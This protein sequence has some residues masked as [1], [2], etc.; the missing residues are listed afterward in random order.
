MM[1]N[2]WAANTPE[3][4]WGCLA[5]IPAEV[6]Q[7]AS[8]HAS[9]ELGLDVPVK[10]VADALYLTLGEG[11][12]GPD[13]WTLS[14]SRRLYY[15]L[16][17]LIPRP[18]RVAMRRLVQARSTPEPVGVP[19]QG[20]LGWPVEERYVRFLWAVMRAV[21]LELGV[22]E[23]PFRDFWPEGKRF[24]LVLTHDIETAEGQAFVP[25]VAALEA[26]LGFRSSFNF[27][28]ERY[29]LDEALI[30]ALRRDGFEVGVHGLNHDGRLFESKAEFDR[31]ASLINRH[32]Q[33]LGAVGFRSP[34]TLRNPYWMQAL[35]IAYDLSFFDTDPYEPMPGGVMTLWPFEIGRF[36]ELPYTLAQDHTLSAVLGERTPRVWLDKL[37]FIKA[38]C[39]M[40]LVNSHPDYLRDK[41]TW[42]IY[43]TFLRTVQGQ[44][45]WHAL[46]RDVA[47][48][49]RRRGNPDGA[50][51][52]PAAP[53]VSIGKLIL[54]KDRVQIQP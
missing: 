42:E 23:L 8:V 2:L 16:K 27:V 7:R 40:A 52:D 53:Q 29:P 17:P 43:A 22:D 44:P 46:P 39:G 5:D 33:R 6:W 11:Q 13:H 37:Q 24:A 41:A 18:A 48:W 3:R 54:R 30:A 49:W 1:D 19:V 15:R 21:M 14:R 10:D 25:Q 26:D 28:P 9:G 35:D 12:F 47:G 31:R 36:M 20:G 51:D 38:H 34:S 50:G 32:A 45:Y 4:F